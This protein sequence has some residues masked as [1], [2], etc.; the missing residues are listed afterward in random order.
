MSPENTNTGA[1]EQHEFR[2][3]VCKLLKIITHSLYT[4][5][6]IFLRELVSNASDALDKLRFAQSRGEAVRAP[7]L[8]SAISITLNK[9]AKTLC[10]ADTGI[11]M[12]R[13][14]LLENLGT[15]ARSGSEKFLQELA[16]S[17]EGSSNI[18]GRFG[19]G[20]YAVFMVADKVSVTSRSYKDGEGAW[21]W[22]S[23][24]LGAFT[25]EPV[26]DDEAPVRGTTI[27]ANIKDDAAEFLEKARLEEIIRKHS[28]FVPFPVRVEGEQVNTTPA[29]WREPKSQISKEQYKDFYKFLSYDEREP[30]GTIH[31]SVDA[32]VQ[33]TALAFIGNTPRDPYEVERGN[34]GLDLYVRRVLIS[35]EYKEL[36]PEY[37]SF[38]TG[39]VDTED[40]PLNI[41]RETLQENALI[42]KIR[43]SLVKQVLNHLEKMAKDDAEAYANFW[44]THGRIFN[45]GYHDYA[46]KDKFLGL[47]RF[48]SSANDDA[49]GLSS[50]EDYKSR[51]PE[52]QK[53]IW[54]L[55]APNRE[56]ARL[57]PH[58]EIFRRKNV[59]ILYLYEPVQE[60]ILESVGTWNELNFK[61]VERVTDDDL[62]HLPDVEKADDSAKHEA[63]DEDGKAELTKLLAHMKTLLGD[64]VDD[65]RVSSR[66]TDSPA[67]LASPDGA[68]T[69]SMERL[70][71]VMQK[72]ESIPR[73]VLEINPDHSLTRN[74]LRVF[75][76]DPTD[77]LLSQVTEQI[78]ESALLLEGYL[79]DPH[80]LVNHVNSLLEK[81]TGWYAEVRKL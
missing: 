81:A 12:T 36:I 46:N 79:R 77:A 40:L 50:L 44:K 22:T 80:S 69:A 74:M 17:G 34:Y 41:S 39:V 8:E 42:R 9:D 26:A 72:D 28:N 43:Q 61:A 63:L 5:H 45:L 78:F 49:E 19:V 76:A 24:G 27:V 10:V 62:K 66:L 56:A 6:E 60:F 13:E 37:L 70:M 33:F 71:R 64:K 38:L 58:A 48:N 18:I 21:R 25:L 4:N 7:E 53:D 16:E 20:F 54:Y 35:K 68:M 3:E 75:K 30:L 59:E 1:T 52:G 73:R 47:L 11:G 51:M 2:T 23:D 15:I 14:D 67:C 29:L 57:N 32:P 65:V 55:S 31:L